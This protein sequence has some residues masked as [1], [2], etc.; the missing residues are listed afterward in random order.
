M[1]SIHLFFLQSEN[2]P[3]ITGRKAQGLS[4]TGRKLLK[5]TE[6]VWKAVNNAKC[7]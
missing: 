6:Y 1:V 3:G 7:A 5:G 2:Q 4:L